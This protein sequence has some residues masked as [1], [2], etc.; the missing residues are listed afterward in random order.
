MQMPFPPPGPMG[1]PMMP[2]M[3]G[4]GM[5]WMMNPG[6]MNG[7]NAYDPN[8]AQ[9]DMTAPSMDLEGPAGVLP[10][11]QVMMN[12]NGALYMT[13]AGMP[14]EGGPEP[15]AESRPQDN[16]G[17]PPRPRRGGGGGRGRGGAHGD[18]NSRGDPFQ[19]FEKNEKTLVVERIPHDHLSPPALKD[20][21]S[22]FGTI[23]NVAVDAPTAKALVSF[24]T[25]DQARVAWKSED[26]VF[27]NRFVK[28]FWHRPLEGKGKA[29]ANALAASAEP[30]TSAKPAV[31]QPSPAELV[32]MA[33]KRSVLERQIAEQ[34]VLMARLAKG[35]PEEKKE[36]MTRLRKLN[37]DM[38]APAAAPPPQP[39][40]ED[41]RVK[42]ETEK[43]DRELE[44]HSAKAEAAP[45]GDAEMG[46][47]EAEAAKARKAELLAKVA[48]LRSEV[49]LCYVFFA[50]GVH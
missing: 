12:G 45:T 15:G 17:H 8:E 43:L 40:S 13:N 4:F 42:M 2:M 23:T 37:E 49:C 6:A 10:Q 22:K 11:D 20:W 31:P 3:P 29:G 28:L 33:A 36:I 44:S 26:A 5:P 27:G 25:H 32:V 21:F 35:T 41:E 14:T 7:S 34:K 9:M 18:R 1:F 39:R 38:K 50:V 19:H 46:E 16:R 47:V 48:A 30:S 24:E